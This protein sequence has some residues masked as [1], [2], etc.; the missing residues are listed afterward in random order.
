MYEH[1]A[2]P[3]PPALRVSSWLAPGS[4]VIDGQSCIITVIIGNLASLVAKLV[5][6]G[7]VKYSVAE[8]LLVSQ[9]EG[10]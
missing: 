6:D 8:Q 9:Y 1:R 7:Y 4:E 2:P 5:S 3:P 10:R